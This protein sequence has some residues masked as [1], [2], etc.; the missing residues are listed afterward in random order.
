MHLHSTQ[1][2]RPTL[3]DTRNVL[4]TEV[5]MT[6]MLVLLMNKKLLHEKCSET[7]LGPVKDVVLFGQYG[8]K[9]GYSN[10]Q[11]GYLDS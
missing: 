4:T 8:L 2:H 3:N 1:C 10:V 11:A 9:I 5:C 6:P 7:Y